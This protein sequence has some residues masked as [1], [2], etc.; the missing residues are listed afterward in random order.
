MK[1][2]PNISKPSYSQHA[3]RLRK[4]GVGACRAGLTIKFV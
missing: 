2:T 3:M 1:T 4:D